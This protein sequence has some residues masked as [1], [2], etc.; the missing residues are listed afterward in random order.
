MQRDFARLV[1]DTTARERFLREPRGES[2]ALAALSPRALDDY[3]RAL[4]EKRFYE[5]RRLL[6]RS[7][8]AA[9]FRERFVAY[10]ARRP[11]GGLERHHRDAIEFARELATPTARAERMG[12]LALR[13]RAFFAIT[14]AD[15]HL[16][17]WLRSL[18]GARLRTMSFRLG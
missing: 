6:P 9:D 15:G 3:A 18:R 2:V 8:R 11:I 17:I 12:L 4:L 14:I 5:V 1:G 7:A 16:L 10:A 13:D